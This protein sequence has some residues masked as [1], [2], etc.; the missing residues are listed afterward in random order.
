MRV[1]LVVVLDP[2]GKRCQRGE[3]IWKRRDA[4]V[5]AFEREYESLRNAVGLRAADRSETG[6]QTQL[7]GRRF[8]SHGRYRPSRCRT[9][10]RPAW[11]HACRRGGFP[12]LPARCRADAGIGDRAPG[13]D[14]SVVSVDDEGAA[15]D[16]TVPAGEPKAVRAPAQVRADR[17]HDAIMPVAGP[18]GVAPRQQQAVRRH[19][20]IDELVVDRR[21]SFGALLSIEDR[22][23]AAVAVCG[24]LRGD[25]ADAGQQIGKDISLRSGDSHKPPP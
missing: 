12:R 5:I 13:D 20:A 16:L 18:L 21:Q 11:S 7:P 3:R 17:H 10:S 23:G 24:P 19:D 8:A 2:S 15:Y 14:L 1:H 22:R 25:L 4:D 9:A 6:F